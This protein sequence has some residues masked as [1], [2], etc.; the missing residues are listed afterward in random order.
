MRTQNVGLPILKNAGGERTSLANVLRAKPMGVAEEIPRREIACEDRKP[1]PMER[2]CL[3][4]DAAKT[5]GNARRIRETMT[6][7]EQNQMTVPQI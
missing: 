6:L 7:D 2:Q 5:L 1:S 4:E 3:H